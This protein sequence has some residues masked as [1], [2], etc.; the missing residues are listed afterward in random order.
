MAR[1]DEKCSQGDRGNRG[2]GGQHADQD[3]LDRAREQYPRDERGQPPG[4]AV[5]GDDHSQPDTEGK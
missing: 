2:A 1:I 4:E 3:E 5:G